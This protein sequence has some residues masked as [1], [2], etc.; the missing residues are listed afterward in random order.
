M[1]TAV[2]TLQGAVVTLRP[3][4]PRDASSLFSVTPPDTFRLF[5]SWPAEWTL[6][7]FEAWM[8]AKLFG[9]K[10]C[11]LLVQRTGTDEVVGCSSFLD[12]DPTNKAVEIGSTR[13]AASAR[14]TKVNPEAKLLMLAHAF[15]AEHCVRVT[16]KTDPTNEHSRRAMTKLGATL[17]GVLRKHRIRQNGVPRDTAYFSVI[18][19]EW[20]TIKDSLL[21][22]LG[23]TN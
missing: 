14:G 1:F 7:A 21:Q 20:P 18:S 23:A 12:I 11:G 17:E 16:L 10:Q 3:L 8:N 4:E 15:E 22:R 2:P 13:F 6:P 19:D 5:L 9:P